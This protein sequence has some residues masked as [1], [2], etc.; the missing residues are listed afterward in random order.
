MHFGF[1]N[2]A[3]T[4]FD[5][6]LSKNLSLIC[7]FDLLILCVLLFFHYIPISIKFLSEFGIL[8]SPSACEINL[9]QPKDY[10]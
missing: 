3:L 7:I 9:V 6:F 10:K 4:Y 2:L 1:G 8:L 5:Q